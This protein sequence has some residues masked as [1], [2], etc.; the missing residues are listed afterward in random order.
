MNDVAELVP[1]SSLKDP[2]TLSGL[3]VDDA[4][5]YKD[6]VIYQLNVKS[7]VDSNDDG[8]GDFP[9]LTSKLGYIRDLGVN[10]IWLMPFYPS[11]LKDDGYDIAD[12]KNIHPST[13]LWKISRSCCAR[14]TGCGLKVVTELI[15]NHTSDQH[16][17]SKR[18]AHAPPGSPE[19]GLLR[20]ERH[21]SEV[22]R[23]HHLPRHRDLQLDLRPGGQAILLAP[24]LQPSAGSEFRQ[25]ARHGSGA[26][27][28]AVLAGHGGRRLPP[29][30]HP[31]SGRARGNEQREPARDARGHQAAARTLDANYRDRFLLAEAN[32]W[33]EDVREYFGDGD[34]CHMAY[35]LPAD[36][37]HL[38]GDRTGGSV[39][40]H[41][42]HAA[43]ARYSRVSMG[44]L[45]SQ[46]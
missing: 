3:D 10:T 34:E 26:R 15:I 21:R 36:A 24:L 38:H 46:P 33:P 9:G 8:I 27:H 1:Q 37:S 12:Y 16:P 4:L 35:S 45:S 5:W 13:A 25:P 31:L 19:A 20:L 14:R 43:D 39:S 22:P 2:G 28:H 44:D 18:P 32:Q 11:P 29:R 42:N 30:R 6:A 7:F 23:T 17:G 40:D 41:R